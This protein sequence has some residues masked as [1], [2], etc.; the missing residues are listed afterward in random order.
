MVERDLHISDM[1]MVRRYWQENI[2][3]APDR[4]NITYFVWTSLG[5]P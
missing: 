2:W 5:K 4:W 3:D 1:E